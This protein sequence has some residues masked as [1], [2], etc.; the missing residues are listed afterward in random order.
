MVRKGEPERESVLHAWWR[1]KRLGGGQSRRPGDVVDGG[2]EEIERDCWRLRQKVERD[3][4]THQDRSNVEDI[5]ESTARLPKPSVNDVVTDADELNRAER[6]REA[7]ATS[8]AAKKMEGKELMIPPGRL[9]WLNRRN[10]LKS[11][12][13]GNPGPSSWDLFEVRDPPRFFALPWFETCLLDEHMPLTYEE[14]CSGLVD[15][16]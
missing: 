8:E 13:T 11:S 16:S 5:D 15:E 14:G 9:Y 1:W 7:M 3:L 12:S 2:I 6:L 10:V 4:F